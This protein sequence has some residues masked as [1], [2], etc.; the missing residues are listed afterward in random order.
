MVVIV[1]RVGFLVLPQETAFMDLVVD[2]LGLM[3]MKHVSKCGN[4]QVVSV[5]FLH[6]K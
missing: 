5:R 2:H 4:Q 3:H 6:N 1:G